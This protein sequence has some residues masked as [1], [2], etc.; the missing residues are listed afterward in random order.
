MEHCGNQYPTN[1]W[2]VK[3][4]AQAG[5]MGLR[6]G[7]HW[8]VRNNVIRYANTDAIDIGIH[9]GDNE[10]A[11]TTAPNAPKGEDN[12]I[13][14]NYIMDNGAGGITG[15]V[16]TRVII[17]DNVVL[18]NNRLGFIG[19]KRYE[20]AG[21]K[22]HNPQQG[23]IE[24]NYIA[25][26]QRCEGIWMDNNFTNARATRN[27]VVN[28]GGRGIFLE[29]SDY[30]FD[31]A[32][33]DHNISTGNSSI[34]F[35]IHDAS[36]ST[37]MHNLFANSPADAKYG[38]GC[39]ILQVDP[40]TRTG[41]HSLYN[42]IFVAH[43]SMMDIN[44]PAHRGG[45][46]RMDH[47]VY[48]ATPTSRSFFINRA[49]DVPSPWKPEEFFEMMKKDVGKGQ[50]AAIDGGGK[51]ALTLSEWKAFWATHGQQ[52][53]RGSVM[54]QEMKVSYDAKTQELRID[55]P[56]DPATVGSTPHK[57]VQSDFLGKPVP[58]D[59]KA[60]PGPFQELQAGANTFNVWDGLPL[61]AEG[62]LPN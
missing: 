4:W 18:R 9:G 37:V 61:L 29:M 5:A 41:N 19:K 31:T 12:L 56:F 44:Y 25:D 46:Q 27:V 8:I 45:P 15:S 40:R 20:H 22:A 55:L 36:G 6:S 42:N 3:A 54:H 32:L 43:K 10:R 59:G 17:R 62:E 58:Q 2:K 14:K 24:H 7:H 49:S 13:E 34:Q 48:D 53:D 35:Y 23:L 16:S 28:N 51:V 38:Q 1:F 52:N 60:K 39:Y 50:P 30:P 11:S 47:N 21:I 33:V 57:K 26:N